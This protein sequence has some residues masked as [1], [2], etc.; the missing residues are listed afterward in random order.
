M[1][2]DA[3]QIAFVAWRKIF[4]QCQL[5]TVISTFG[6][7]FLKV[8]AFGWLYANYPTDI[9]VQSAGYK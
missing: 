4:V 9:F 5:L 8:V 1:L 2:V 3:Y 6:R 7:A